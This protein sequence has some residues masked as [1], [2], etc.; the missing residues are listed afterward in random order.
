MDREGGSMDHCEQSFHQMQELR[1]RCLP[2]PER[3][4][5]FAHLAGCQSC[6]DL[7]DFHD[8]LG[9]A[10]RQLDDSPTEELAA[11]RARVLETIHR[12]A[13]DPDAVIPFSGARP[14]RSWLLPAAATIVL[15]LLAGFM[16]GRRGPA[17]G[18][19]P[20]LAMLDARAR[21][22]NRLQEVE[23]SAHQLSD[24][25]LRDLGDGRVAVGFN[26]VRHVELVRP[27]DDPLLQEVL[28]HALVNSSSLGSRLKAVSFAAGAGEEKVRQALILAVLHDPDLPVRLRALSVLAEQ[29]LGR[30]LQEVLL[31]ILRRDD[32]VQM[33]LLAIELLVERSGLRPEALHSMLANTGSLD[34]PAL[35]TALKTVTRPQLTQGTQGVTP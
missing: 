17:A 11:M 4:Q 21:S 26:V 3:R 23:D 19:E 24:V 8:D 27:G 35:S 13:A 28:V 14:L 34:E 31:Q 18:D 16:A 25:T 20:L 22:N 12:S 10:G 32:A 5:L 9:A 33:R 2:D 15:A 29:P 7:L 6:R 1:H 30:D